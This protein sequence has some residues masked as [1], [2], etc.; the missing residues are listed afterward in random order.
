MF[1]Y[2]RECRRPP[3]NA[4]R[5]SLPPWFRWGTCPRRVCWKWRSATVAN[6]A[7]LPFPRTV[8]NNCWRPVPKA[9]T[10]IRISATISV[11]NGLAAAANP[12]GEKSKWHWAR[13]A[14]ATRP[15][16]YLNRA[17]SY[18]RSDRP[19]PVAPLK[20]APPVHVIRHV[21]ARVVAHHDPEACGGHELLHEIERAEFF[22]LA[23]GGPEIVRRDAHK[24][25]AA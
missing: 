12:P 7:S 21:V 1:W 15:P 9:A 24:A 2:D 14:C 13:S 22:A 19:Q 20:R 10:S 25:H 4:S 8:W 18:L 23:A 16:P 17:G 5:W 6:I 11:F 3:G